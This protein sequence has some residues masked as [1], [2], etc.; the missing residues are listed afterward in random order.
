MAEY[1]SIGNFNTY[2]VLSYWGFSKDTYGT[3]HRMF[4]W[5]M[6]DTPFSE[7]LAASIGSDPYQ[8]LIPA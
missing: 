4:D 6:I 2:G 8:F 5:Y 1:D 3:Y 7:S